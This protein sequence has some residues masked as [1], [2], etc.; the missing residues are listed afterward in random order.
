VFGASQLSTT[1]PVFVGRVE[2]HIAVRTG[3]W[4][5]WLPIDSEGRFP[6]VDDIVPRIANMDTSV[7]LHPSDAAFLIENLPRLPKAELD[8]NAVTLDL[9]GSV[10]VRSRGEA[11]TP[12]TELKLTNSTKTGTDTRLVTDRTYLARALAM[13]LTRL[14]FSDPA[15]P[16]LAQD[17]RHSYVWATLEKEGAIKPSEDAIVVESPWAPTKINPGRFPTVRSTPL[18]KPKPVSQPV[19][20]EPAG[21][22]VTSSAVP[23][24]AATDA[25]P[26]TSPIEQAIHLRGVLREALT[27]TND[28]IGSLKRQQKQQR[29]YK[30]AIASLKELQ[31]VA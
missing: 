11:G 19:A 22:V 10:L 27:A 17:D 15:S 26:S 16:I 12:P 21:P 31:G 29:A 9:N 18:P 1:D 13:G 8:S 5:F 14:H 3:P 20:A 2:K 30:T 28:L 24:N 4:T 25:S 23:D 6:R 7:E